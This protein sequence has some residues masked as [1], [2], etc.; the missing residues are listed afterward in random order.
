MTITR[1]QILP[2]LNSI[3][4]LEKNENFSMLTKYKVLKIKEILLKEHEY[5]ST[6]FKEMVSKYG[7]VS[8]K[9]DVLIKEENVLKAEKE[10]NEFNNDTIILPDLIFTLDELEGQDIPWSALESFLPFIRE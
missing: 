2:L 5:T 10:L 6:L 4:L 7:A 9:G 8:E 3:Q 1:K